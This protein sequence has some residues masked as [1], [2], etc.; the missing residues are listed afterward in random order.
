MIRKKKNVSNFIYYFSLSYFLTLVVVPYPPRP[1]NNQTPSLVSLSL[2]ISLSIEP[3]KGHFLTYTSHKR[4]IHVFKKKKKK[5]ETSI[6]FIP[7]HFFS[8]R[9]LSLISMWNLSATTPT[10]IDQNPSTK[11][12]QKSLQHLKIPNPNQITKE[13]SWLAHTIHIYK[14]TLLFPSTRKK[15]VLI[16]YRRES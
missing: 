13:A 11:N 12:S 16:L 8:P 6:H 2:S 10:Q 7:C 1:Q 3:L 14:H 15:K 5:K 9:P 4:N